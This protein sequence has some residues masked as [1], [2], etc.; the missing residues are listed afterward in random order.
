M[1]F[2]VSVAQVGLEPT[3]SLVLSQGGLPL[4]TEP[5]V[6]SRFVKAEAVRLELTSG[7]AATCFQDKFLIQ[8]DDLRIKKFRG[9]GIEPTTSWFRAKRHYQQQLPRSMRSWDTAIATEVRGE[10][11]EP[12]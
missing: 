7:K 5:L 3:A 4:P 2:V 10:G 12:S 8:P 1:L 11:L 9:V 6:S